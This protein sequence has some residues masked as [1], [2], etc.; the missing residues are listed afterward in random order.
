MGR[1]KKIIQ[2]V[3]LHLKKIPL[4]IK[5]NAFL[6]RRSFKLN[7]K[8]LEEFYECKQIP[9]LDRNLK[10]L[11][12]NQTKPARHVFLVGTLET[13]DRSG[14]FQALEKIFDEISYFTKKDGS[15]GLE[16]NPDGR[17]F[18]KTIRDRN[19][20]Q[21]EFLIKSSIRKPDLIIGQM[22]GLSID[23]KLLK[24]LR[25]SGIIVINISD[26]DRM[27]IFW[28]YDKKNNLRLGGIELA[29][30]VNITLSTCSD[31]VAW[32]HKEGANAAHMSFASDMKIFSGF[33][34]RDIPISFI[35]SK[36][37]YRVNLVDA[38]RKAGL[39]IAVYGNGWPNG[40]LGIVDSANINARSKIILG[41]G[42]VEHMLDVY[43]LKL[44]DF[45]AMM[46]GAC[47]ITHR[48][49]ELLKFF[50]EGKHLY[51]Y[52]DLS[53]LI[54]IVKAAISNP[55]KTREIGLEAQ[56]KMR[57]EFTWEKMFKRKF[58]EIGLKY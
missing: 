17:Y 24:K 34:E 42:L 53:E 26:N 44:R 7:Q 50:E 56:R 54:Y 21:L 51:C 18:N 29:K 9:F 5:I 22:M 49:P 27:P 37:G 55:E 58:D 40:P 43:T 35:G 28:R 19:T 8:K 36:Y 48:N 39:E 57:K 12:G 20:E 25:E 4:A 6:K 33:I 31:R 13:Q 32:Y 45:D 3:K 11:Y 2:R 47:Y 14:M 52:E 23:P 16:E 10:K 41:S 15:Y 38:I 46:S 1:Y 30:S